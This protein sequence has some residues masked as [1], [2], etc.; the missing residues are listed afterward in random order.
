MKI[1]HDACKLKTVLGSV[2]VEVLIF[3][4][5]LVAEETHDLFPNVLF[6]LVH[7]VHLQFALRFEWPLL[8]YLTGKINLGAESQVLMTILNLEERPTSIKMRALHSVE[9]A[10]CLVIM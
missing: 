5:K 10:L 3:G 8:A 4:E 9:V 1:L 6:T 2:R 7:L